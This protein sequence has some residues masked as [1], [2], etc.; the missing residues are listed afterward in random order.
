[1]NNREESS[2]KFYCIHGNLQSCEVWEPFRGKFQ[3]Q[4]TTVSLECE[5]LLQ[6]TAAGFQDWTK[7]FCAK[8]EAEASGDKP[9]LLGYSLGGRLA[10]HALLERPD[11]WRGVILVAADTG[12]ADSEEKQRQLQ[13]DL[14]WADRFLTEDLEELLAEWDALPVFSQFPN[15]APGERTQLNPKNIAQIFDRFSKGRQED[16]LPALKQIRSAPLLYLSGAMDKKYS[17]L[18]KELAEC[19]PSVQHIII[20][21]AGHRVPW[22]NPVG[23]VKTTQAFID[24]LG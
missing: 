16:M 5:D 21:N 3:Y 4:G 20:P 2:A 9:F 13:N 6:S 22:E 1:M 11:L 12:L 10:L 7:S 19:C 15:L 23:F 17:Q 14:Q 8:V 24:S 18:G